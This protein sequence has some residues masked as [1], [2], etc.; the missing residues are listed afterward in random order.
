MFKKVIYKSKFCISFFNNFRFF[1]GNCAV[2][3][4]AQGVLN[5][6]HINMYKLTLTRRLKKIVTLHIMFNPLRPITSKPSQVRMGKGKGSF[7]EFVHYVGKFETIFEIS[8]ITAEKKNII[9]S[10]LAVANH[11]LPLPVRVIYD[12]NVHP[13][14]T[15]NTDDSAK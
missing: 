14:N 8:Y 10:S 7:N 3:A 15:F 5:K 12:L 6:R 9:L 2:V 4:M 13:F 1:F 11:K